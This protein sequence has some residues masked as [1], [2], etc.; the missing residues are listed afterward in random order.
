VIVSY[1]VAHEDA[2]RF[3]RPTGGVGQ[4][5]IRFVDVSCSENDLAFRSAPQ[6]QDSRG[7]S[8]R[9]L[10]FLIQTSAYTIVR[11]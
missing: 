10:P 8:G 11:T 9:L 6:S 2:D 4:P 7:A 1:E 3:P 5:D